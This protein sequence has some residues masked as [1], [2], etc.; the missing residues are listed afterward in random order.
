M[1]EKNNASQGFVDKSN[2]EIPADFKK[3]VEEQYKKIQTTELT[4][5]QFFEQ[6]KNEFFRL[7][8]V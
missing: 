1:N 2:A 5:E 7:K 6:Q 4:K 8:A 3:Q